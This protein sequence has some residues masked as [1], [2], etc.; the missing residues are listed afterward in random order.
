MIDRSARLSAPHSTLHFGAVEKSLAAEIQLAGKEALNALADHDWEEMNRLFSEYG[1][2]SL[3]SWRDADGETLLIRAALEGADHWIEQLLPFSDPRLTTQD[4]LSALWAA[5]RNS[6]AQSIELLLPDS[7]AES[8]DWI[9]VSPLMAAADRGDEGVDA[10]RALLGVQTKHDS[11]RAALDERRLFF[12]AIDAALNGAGFGPLAL[13]IERAKG[14]SK[15]QAQ[16]ASEAVSVVVER[17]ARENHQ[18]DPIE[19]WGLRALIMIAPHAS[20]ESLRRSLE[21][22]QAPDSLLGFIHA[23]LVE[24]E[25]HGVLGSPDLKTPCTRKSAPGRL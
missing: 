7:D 11:L 24:R 20:S 2:V 25:L 14:Q 13:L 6:G 1:A 23:A 17:V 8:A 19:A 9:G 5:A 16:M 21:N 12:R 10:M 4:G 18:N 3:G 15:I 22:D